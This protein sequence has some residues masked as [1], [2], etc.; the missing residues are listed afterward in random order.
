MF[1]Y[2]KANKCQLNEE[3]S[4]IYQAAYCGLCK[5]LGKNYG[6][7]SRLTLSFDLSFLAILL[8]SQSEEKVSISYKRCGLNLKKKPF[9][10]FKSETYRYV[11]SV[12]MMLNFYK[13]KDN[14][15]DK[16]G[17]KKLAFLVLK[18][19]F[20]AKNKKASRLYPH[21][22]SV[23]KEMYKNQ[24]TVEKNST[25]DIDMSAEPTS[26]ALSKIFSYPLD[27]NKEE[28]SNMGYCLGKWIYLIDAV[29]DLEKD[30]KSGNFN[31][32]ITDCDIDEN[33]SLEALRKEIEP[34]LCNCISVAY[35][36]YKKL[37]IKRFD[38]VLDNII[39]LGLDSSKEQ[40]FSNRKGEKA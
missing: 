10:N 23:I 19:Y 38:G 33:S 15:D 13:L 1:G 40:I 22:S 30:K 28:L 3:D 6:I 18:P 21:I 17:F 36:N 37:S 8:L 4:E 34:I 11:S 16:M 24:N 29:D 39:R 12:S 32:L 26:R 20:S 5:A 35:D 7:C 25:A 14:I 27:N 2:V 31:P 9:V